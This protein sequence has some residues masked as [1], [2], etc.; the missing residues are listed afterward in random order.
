M[1]FIN[2]KGIS[3]KG[4]IRHTDTGRQER[5]LTPKAVAE[6]LSGTYICL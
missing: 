1:V 6:V 5:M 4:Y 2:P 3:S